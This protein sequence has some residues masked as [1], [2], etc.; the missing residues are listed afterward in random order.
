MLRFISRILMISTFFVGL[1]A[2][3]DTALKAIS[4]NNSECEKVI[5]IDDFE[6]PIEGRKIIILRKDSQAF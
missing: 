6:K 2:I 3:A 1:G 4:P 5:K